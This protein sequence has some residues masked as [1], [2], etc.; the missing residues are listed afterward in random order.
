MALT[1][2]VAITKPS[3]GTGVSKSDFGDDVVDDLN[4]LH[5]LE[6]M[7]IYIPLNDATPLTT[8]A[9]GYWRVPSK[10]DGGSL[11]GVAA[12]CKDGSS[13]GEIELAVKNGATSMLS[14]NITIDQTETDT[15]TAAVAAVISAPTLA[16]GDF[17]EISVV[18]SGTGVTY[19]ACELTV[20]PS[21]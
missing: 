1:P 11:I 21:A 4:R 2:Y 9:K 18:Q 20:R 5:T 14:T 8:S 17:I 15:L 13:S 6:D 16:V 3:V 10:F 12:C 19:C 7:S